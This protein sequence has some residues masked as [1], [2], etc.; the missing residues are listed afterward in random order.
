MCWI[1]HK[2]TM[3]GQIP[4]ALSKL[5]QLCFIL[6]GFVLCVHLF[7]SEK[8]GCTPDHS[9]HDRMLQLIC[10]HIYP[11]HTL[12]SHTI[13]KKKKS[14][15]KW[16]S[17]ED[18]YFKIFYLVLGLQK[19]LMWLKRRGNDFV[20][21]IHVLLLLPFWLRRALLS[22]QLKLEGERST[23]LSTKTRSCNLSVICFF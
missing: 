1:F 8:F 19:M 5:W 7:P 18:D 17:G 11:Q 21:H 20:F 14:N 10:T 12:Q 23:V 13:C 3:S 16:R 4:A 6:Q 22:L 15:W 2:H 9:Y